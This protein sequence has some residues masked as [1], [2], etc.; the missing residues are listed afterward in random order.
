M[1]KL[2]E[3]LGKS[4]KV[5]EADDD[6]LSQYWDAEEQEEKE[7]DDDISSMHMIRSDTDDV[8]EAIPGIPT[9]SE[10]SFAERMT[11]GASVSRRPVRKEIGTALLSHR[12]PS[13]RLSSSPSSMREGGGGFDSSRPSFASCPPPTPPMTDTEPAAAPPDIQLPSDSDEAAP[14]PTPLQPGKIDAATYAEANAAALGP[15]P[16]ASTLDGGGRA[17]SSDDTSLGRLRVVTIS[18]DAANGGPA[19]NA[20]P[21]AT[22]RAPSFR[23]DSS[24]TRAMATPTGP[25]RNTFDKQ[26]KKTRMQTMME[27]VKHG[28][29]L[30]ERI[31]RNRRGVRVRAATNRDRATSSGTGLER[32]HG[33]SAAALSRRDDDA[34]AAD[35]EAARAAAGRAGPPLRTQASDMSGRGTAGL[36][37]QTTRG[38]AALTPLKGIV[39]GKVPPAEADADA[40]RLFGR[41]WESYQ[42]HDDSSRVHLEIRAA[43]SSRHQLMVLWAEIGFVVA[44]GALLACI[45]AAIFYCEAVVIN[46]RRTLIAMSFAPCTSV[47]GADGLWW[48]GD[49]TGEGE[50]GLPR[51]APQS[52]WRAYATYALYNTFLIFLASCFTYWA[53]MA[54]ASGL[55]PLKAF[56]NGVAVPDLLVARTLVAKV[57]GV[58]LVVSTGLPLGREGPMVHTGAIVAARVTRA[59]VKIPTALRRRFGWPRKLTTPVQ[60]RVPSAQINWIGVGCAAGVAAAFN[61][62]LGGILYSFEEV[63]S[64]WNAK[65]T[66]RA[67][68]CVVVAAVVY[69][70]CI[71]AGQEGSILLNQGLVLDLD[72]TGLSS[73]SEVHYLI[74]AILGALGGVAG[75]MYVNCV[76][77]FNRLRRRLLG[78]SK[79][80][81]V[82]EATLLSFVIFTIWFWVPLAFPCKDK[83]ASAYGGGGAY[84]GSSSS[85]Y[86]GTS[87]AYGGRRLLDGAAGA[88]GDYYLPLPL[89]S[90]RRALAGGGEARLEAWQCPDGQYNPMASIMHTGQ[91]GVILHFFDRSASGGGHRQRRSLAASGGGG[92]VEDDSLKWQIVLPFLLIYFVLAVIVFG[93]FVP[94]GNFIP[95]L[96]IG[97]ALGRLVGTILVDGMGVETDPGWWS[98]MGAAA[99]LGGVTRMTLTL[100]VILTE[101]TDDAKAMLPMMFVLTAAKIV[102]DMISPSFDHAMMHLWELPFLDEEPLHE[103]HHLIARDV[104]RS[105]V[106]VLPERML[107]GNLVR[108]LKGTP[109]HGYPIVSVDGLAESKPYFAGLILRRQLL[110]LIKERVWDLQANDEWLT[111][112]AMRRYVDSAFRRH[113]MLDLEQVKLSVADMESSID[114]RPFMDPSPYIVSDLMPIKRVYD[115]FN[116]VGVRHLAVIDCREEVVGIITRKDILTE[117]IEERIVAAAERLLDKANQPSG[118]RSAGRRGS[119]KIEASVHATLET[120]RMRST[121]S[122]TRRNLSSHNNSGR[123][124]TF[125]GLHDGL[126]VVRRVTSSPL[127][128]MTRMRSKSRRNSGSST[129]DRPV[130]PSSGSHRPA[131]PSTAG[132]TSDNNALAPSDAQCRSDRI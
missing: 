110:V 91:E 19:R 21:A 29:N 27:F 113:E 117:T 77:F 32:G 36:L 124:T 30:L 26:Q 109:H 2:R 17:S 56:L 41:Q 119:S 73:F 88:A 20:S 69:N 105:Q 5:V 34:A 115:Y 52:L 82:A 79:R 54:T 16:P 18:E 118:V 43:E 121:I 49:C 70:L 10:W 76:V 83:V 132:G 65:M 8:Q 38:G 47:S 59:T 126:S 78:P 96:T 63:C 104:M 101:V 33:E 24:F 67:F 25:D 48:G 95:A 62:P 23:E 71:T 130:T 74:L 84:N 99:V 15:P 94:A 64:H 86:N 40:H 81:K 61:A 72:F 66:W 125:L 98:L 22:R 129:S 28:P 35:V 87:A 90:M 92:G 57:L 89:A 13:S 112:A 128:P 120:A 103:F 31:E 114:L 53:P 75:A 85:S 51:D 39:D 6:T 127:S 11:S 46:G 60:A 50:A 9:S 3:M 1:E 116:V 4:G 102:G 14:A 7:L 122:G 108:V 44:I 131:S 97:A 123:G 37:R 80:V 12:E 111:P 68:F 45:A 106:Y 42:I 100:A 107:V 55:P 58:T 93:I